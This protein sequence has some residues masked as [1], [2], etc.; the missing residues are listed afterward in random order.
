MFRGTSEIKLD[1]KGR[2]A[3]PRKIRQA[4]LD[5]YADQLVVTVN[6]L[7]SANNPDRC[8]WLYPATHWQ[9]IEQK[10]QAE[11]NSKDNIRSLQRLFIGHAEDI[12]PDS[13]GRILLSMP[14]RRYAGLKRD[15]VMVGQ[16]NK[17][18]IWDNQA[19]Q[20]YIEN[21]TASQE[22]NSVMEDQGLDTLEDLSVNLSL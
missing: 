20:T 9:A 18:E 8:L 19:W 22:S 21:I 7:Y 5:N 13:A 6:P 16:G 1:S 11:P 10:V 4:I 17:W 15:L 14:L 2:L 12:K 3:L